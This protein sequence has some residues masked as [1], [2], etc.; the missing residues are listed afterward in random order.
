MSA[1][2][3]QSESDSRFA[4]GGDFTLAHNRVTMVERTGSQ[5]PP[6]AVTLFDI[7]SIGQIRLTD[8]VQNDTRVMYFNTTSQPVM[9]SFASTVSPGQSVTV[10]GPQAW[11]WYLVSTDSAGQ[12]AT[13]SLSA[14][15]GS[16][17]SAQGQ[18]AITTAG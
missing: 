17:C 11:V 14:L 1:Y 10:D 3:T 6:P 18:A 8:C 4:H 15:A 5:P 16:V 13:V 2:Y 9:T 12:S 7:A